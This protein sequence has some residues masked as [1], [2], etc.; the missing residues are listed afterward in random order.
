MKILAPP[1]RN[2]CPRCWSSLHS[3]TS[4]RQL[5]SGYPNLI[6]QPRI[7]IFLAS[8]GWFSTY[9]PFSFEFPSSLSN[10]DY[11]FLHCLTAFKYNLNTHSLMLW[12]GQ[13]FLG[14][15]APVN[16]SIRVLLIRHTSYWFLRWNY[17]ALHYIYRHWNIVLIKN[18]MEWSLFWAA[19]SSRL[20]DLLIGVLRH[21]VSTK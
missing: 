1:L 4:S 12:S 21:H 5:R 8:R 6:S 16:N 20:I 15:L 11:R 18:C 3:Y 19:L 17:I 2:V 7:N 14:I 13:A 10:L 9:W